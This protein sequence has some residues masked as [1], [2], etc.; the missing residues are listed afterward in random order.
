MTHLSWMNFFA[1]LVSGMDTF[2]LIARKAVVLLP[3][4]TMAYHVLAIVTVME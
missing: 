3:T 2:V 4:H 1:V